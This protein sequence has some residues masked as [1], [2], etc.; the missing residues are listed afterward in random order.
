LVE[1]TDALDNATAFGHSALHQREAQTNANDDGT[2]HDGL[3]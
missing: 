3:D 2:L 1:I